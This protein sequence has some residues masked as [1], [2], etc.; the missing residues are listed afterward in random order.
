M[1]SKGH[2]VSH[3]TVRKHMRQSLKVLPFKPQLHPLLTAVQKANWVKFCRERKSWDIE[4]WRRVLFSDE[5]PFEL[6]HPPN[7]QNDQI[8]ARDKEEVPPAFTVKH[9]LKIQVWGLMSFIALSERQVLPEKQMVMGAYYVDEIPEKSLLPTL[10]RTRETGSTL[11]RK[12]LPDMST[13]IFQQD[14]A[15]AHTS[16]VAMKWLENNLNSFWGKGVWPGNTPDPSP[17]KN[18]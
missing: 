16:K 8:W 12:L 7:H 15:P 13:A 2:K 10:K 4:E 9:P 5:S 6:F 17:I 11:Q 14:R 18:L 1:T 3:E